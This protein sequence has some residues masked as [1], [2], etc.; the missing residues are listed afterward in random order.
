ME[1]EIKCIICGSSNYKLR[2][3]DDTIEL[4]DEECDRVVFEIPEDEIITPIQPEDKSAFPLS[5]EL[6]SM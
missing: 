4:Y 3:R 5:S 2:K 6:Q 1:G